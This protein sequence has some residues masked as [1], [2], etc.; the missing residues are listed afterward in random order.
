MIEESKLKLSFIMSHSIKYD[1]DSEQMI[2][3]SKLSGY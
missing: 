1:L 3:E 2:E